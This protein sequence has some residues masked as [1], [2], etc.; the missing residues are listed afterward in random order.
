MSAPKDKQ[1]I[2]SFTDL[3][4]WQEGH[5][6]VLMVYNVT[7]SFPKEELFGLT[8]QMR[9]AVVS[10]TANISEGFGRQSYKEK[11]Q[12]YS[13]SRGSTTELQSH[14]LVARDIGLLQ[15]K[16]FEEISQQ[17]T[18]THKLITGLV[19]KSRTFTL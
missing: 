5:K 15:Q 3:H 17:S 19:T 7:R 14:I 8:S 11:V 13:I 4:A 18:L 10:I 12:F 9:R 16:P 2:S 6:L 1:K